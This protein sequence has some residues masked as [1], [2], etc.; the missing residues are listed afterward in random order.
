[1]SE[2]IETT[3]PNEP[4][5]APDAAP[6]VAAND[7]ALPAQPP[8]H[9]PQLLLP[10]NLA[11]LSAICADGETRFSATNGVRLERHGEDGPCAVPTYRAIATDGRCLA[12]VDGPSTAPPD[13]FPSIAALDSAPNGA[14]SAVIDRKDWVAA[15]KAIPKLPRALNSSEK[16]DMLSSLAVTMGDKVTT[17]A[18]TNL[19]RSSVVQP[20]NL[21][22]RFP[23]Y[24]QVVPSDSDGNGPVLKIDVDPQLLAELLTVAAAFTGEESR[25]VTLT[26]YGPKKPFKLSH[27]NPETQQEFT[28]VIVPL[29]IR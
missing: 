9:P 11:S 26:F 4:Q 2:P 16:R 18:A 19:E 3:V 13:A 22:G 6:I 1:M 21:E 14:T 17:L 5:A 25:R 15:F 8:R 20:A 24:A 29:S 23:P 10:R 27:K 7:L 12:I 28:G